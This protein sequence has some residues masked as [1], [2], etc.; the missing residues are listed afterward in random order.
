[1]KLKNRMPT[2][3]IESLRD[4]I[5]SIRKDLASIM[6]G[7]IGI[8]ADRTSEVIGQ[9]KHFVKDA[10]ERAKETANEMHHKLADT[11]AERPL[12]TIAVAALAGAV[13][14]KLIDRLFR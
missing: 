6:S 4:D 1:M 3:S 13:I 7:G 5:S 12:A 8:A 9:A 10:S 11:A 14:V 2:D